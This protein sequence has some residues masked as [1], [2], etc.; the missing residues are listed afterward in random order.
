MN[1]RQQDGAELV[2]ADDNVLCTDFFMQVLSMASGSM[3]K[4][5]VLVLDS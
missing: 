2:S 1:I 5:N 3:T 4:M